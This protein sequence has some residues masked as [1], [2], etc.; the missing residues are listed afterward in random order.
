VH[1]YT[2]VEALIDHADKGID[3]DTQVSMIAL[4]DHEEVGSDSA[5]GAGS[6]VMYDSLSRI[7]ACFTGTTP[8]H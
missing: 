2:S 4:F 3:T 6:P 8:K 7:C 5:A 1:C